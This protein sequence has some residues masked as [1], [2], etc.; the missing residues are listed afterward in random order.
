VPKKSVRHAPAALTAAELRRRVER[1]L[2][3]GR[4]QQAL[5]FAKQL[6]KA[7]P[8]PAHR[9]LL[10][11]VY[12][13]RADQLH[14]QGHDR[15]AVP[16]LLAARPVDAAN[17]AWLEQLA[18]GLARS[19][20]AAE[21]LSLAA[22]L[23][24]E[25]A[26]RVLPAAADAALR[27][28]PAGRALLPDEHRADFDRVVR[29]FAES[30]A[31]NDEAAREALGGIG[32]RSP[33]LEWKLLLRGLLAYYHNDDPRALENWQRLSADR[34]PARLMAPLRAGIDPGFRAAQPPQTQALLQRQFERLQGSPLTAPLRQLR[35]ALDSDRSLAPAFR[36][37]EALLPALRRA[38]PGLAERLASCF[39]WAAIETGPDDLPRY[40]RVFGRPPHDP[41]FNR[42]RALAYERSGDLREAHAFWQKYDQEVADAP[43]LWP[44]GEARRARALI[45]LHM[46]GNAAE[47]PSPEKL[48]RLPAYLRD[49]PDR[50]RP[51]SPSAEKCY[52]RAAELAPDMVEAFRALFQYTLDEGKED[53][54]LKAG[55]RLLARFPDDGP[56]LE[57]LGGLCVRRQEYAGAVELLRRALSG[58]PLDRGLRAKLAS[59]HLGSGRVHATAS[60]FDEARAEYAAARRLL[61]DEPDPHLLC[62]WAATEFKAGD[63]DRGE[64]LL[65]EARARAGSDLSVAYQMLTETLR[66]KL[67]RAFK[68]RFEGEF[69]AGLA[70]PPDGA[71]AAGMATVTA[72]LT[73]LRGLAYVGQKTQARKVLAYLDRARAAA[74]TEPQLMAVCGALVLL[75]SPRLAKQYVR[76][77]RERFP[78]SPHFPFLEAM[79]LSAVEPDRVPVWKVRTLLE[80]AERLAKALPQ[81]EVIKGLLDQIAERQRALAA[82]SP[83]GGGMMD[84]VFRELF[85]GNPFG[86]PDEDDDLDE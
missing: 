57:S 81:D 56:T 73:Q 8:T 80:K 7:D 67:P 19:G 12:L 20:G 29:A 43:A 72:A 77:G 54:A 38:S 16:V 61:G 15:D 4:T 71:A 83:F 14:E 55:R 59:A 62:R 36:Q 3:E 76:L 9:D 32:L 52:E 28:G 75:G 69:N 23:G 26:A 46:G 30:A 84:D 65:A 64:A 27:Q 13:A 60:R 58:N 5:D 50:P 18:A 44:E 39:Y 25:A 66:Q 6:L 2:R 17:P 51:L 74:L 48:A 41:N 86:P 40:Q 49:D 53:K 42:L 85:G 47:V 24:A 63:A 21:A 33:F 35:A 78:R 31:V 10:K 11:R 70:A 45:W 79:Q 82:L 1:T 22:G 37:A 34:L 68:T